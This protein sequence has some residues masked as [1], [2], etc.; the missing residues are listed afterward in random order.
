MSPPHMAVH[1]NELQPYITTVSWQSLP[2][3]QYRRV[4]RHLSLESGDAAYF[5]PRIL[6]CLRTFVPR[7]RRLSDPKASLGRAHCEFRRQ[8]GAFALRGGMVRAP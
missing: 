3:R 5:S 2:L 6:H 1:S 8:S 7:R 4:R